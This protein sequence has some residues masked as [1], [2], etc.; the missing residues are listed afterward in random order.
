MYGIG[1]VS[2]FMETLCQSY[3]QASKS[4]LRYVK[5]TQNDDIFYSYANN[6][7]LGRVTL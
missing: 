2:R 3:L 5:D 6:V 1:I 7:E 4:I